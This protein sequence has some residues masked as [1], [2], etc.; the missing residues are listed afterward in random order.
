M[1]KR[2]T[3]WTEEKIAKYYKEG[4]GKGEFHNYKP[5]LTI[6]D[7]PS[8]G[9]SH[10]FKG[11]KSG[12]QHQ[13]LSDLE[14]NYLLLMDW[15]EDVIDIREQFPLDREY[16][17]K[18]AEEKGINHPVN[19]ENGVPIVMTTDF[20]ISKSEG[21]EIKYLARTTKYSKDLDEKRKIDLFEIERQYWEENQVDFGIVT[22]KD[23]PVIFVE[24]LKKF[25]KSYFS[26]H[27]NTF[28]KLMTQ[29]LRKENGRLINFLNKFEEEYLSEPGEALSVFKH[30]VA[31]KDILL[32]MNTRFTPSKIDIAQLKIRE[33]NT[34]QMRV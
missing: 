31:R 10:R 19:N 18:I 27:E 29:L 22:D 21:G 15:A 1:A 17:M 32:D 20:L 2:K 13:L 33:E 9:R 8:I 7:V 28:L 12:R 24:N 34:D 23:I 11:W 26:N 16:T 5:W 14:K 25:H 30:L 4:R 6:Q 3:G